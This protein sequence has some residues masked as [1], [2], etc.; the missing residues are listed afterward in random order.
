MTY[1]SNIQVDPQDAEIIKIDDLEKK[2][3]KLPDDIKRIRELITRFEV[4]HFKYQ[5]HLAKIKQAIAELKPGVDTTKIGINHIQHGEQVVSSDKTGRSRLGQQ[6]VWA[7]KEWIND[8][9]NESFSEHY[10]K[11]LGQ[12]VQL[13]LGDKTP[14]KLQLVQFLL[15]R[16]TWDWPAYEKLQQGGKFVDLEDQASRVDICHYAFPKNLDLLL[17]GIGQMK[18][19]ENEKW[20]GCGFSNAT[21]KA[22]LETE[23]LALNK[24]LTSYQ[25]NPNLNKDDLMR[26]WLTQCLAK[27]I[28]ADVKIT[29]PMCGLET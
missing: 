5:V 11:S 4:C 8:H 1:W 10:D 13:W 28:K 22:D 6:Y 29:I 18:A 27:T 19:V 2:L 20:E 14:D 7:L 26:L 9:G 23:F 24:L 15:A 17:E 12:Q 16:L 25:N 3:D 21:I